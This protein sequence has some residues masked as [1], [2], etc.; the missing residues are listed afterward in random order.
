MKPVLEM[1]R[2]GRGIDV[3]RLNPHAR[4]QDG[5]HAMSSRRP[6]QLDWPRGYVPEKYDAHLVRWAKPL[7]TTKAWPK[8]IDRSVSNGQASSLISRRKILEPQLG[9]KPPVFARLETLFQHLLGRLACFHPLG[10][11]LW[12]HRVRGHDG[13]QID[14]QCISRGHD[15]IVVDDLD[16]GFQGG[17]LLLCLL[18]CL[19]G[20]LCGGSTQSFVDSASARFFWA[21]SIP[22]PALRGRVP[23]MGRFEGTRGHVPGVSSV[24]FVR[25]FRRLLTFRGY[26]EIPHTRACP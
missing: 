5:P 2:G 12:A 7:S 20:H 3:A 24:G 25:R 8:R 9:E 13:L 15:V 14:V 19:F 16:E 17:P 1:P 11:I 22:R 18:G 23:S 4:P 6:G 10:R 21:R 26:L